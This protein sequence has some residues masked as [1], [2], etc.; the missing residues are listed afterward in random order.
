M[1][2]FVINDVS[3][4]GTVR[5]G[6]SNPVRIMGVLNVSPES[7]YKKSVKRGDVIARAVQMMENEGADFVDVG[8]M[9]TAPY[10]STLVPER[11]EIRRVLDAISRIQ[12]VSNLPISVDTCRSNV[13]MAA[14]NS[15]AEIL[16]DVSG[17]KYDRQMIRVIEK[18]SPSVV[19][20]AYSPRPITGDLM[21][22]TKRLLRQSILLAISAKIKRQNI[23]LDPAIG[24]F[25]NRGRGPF[26]T[27]I[28]SDWLER[29]LNVLQD[30][31]SLKM[32]HPVLVSVSN[33]SF[34]G[35]IIHSKNPSDRI[36]GSLTAEA[37]AVINGADI[38]RTH[39]VRETKS[40][41]SLALKISKKTQERL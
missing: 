27:R 6:G 25:R 24:F 23:V 4:L 35:K 32:N 18:H 11:Q 37:L 34:I 20:C 29:D 40:A 36:F 7:F 9:S 2:Y 38:V 28:K 31:S 13:A 8:G 15:G 3:K 14:L 22:Q 19:L 12:R 1:A 5:V 17:L 21:L 26:Y 41:V 39:N 30:L 10:L 33:K 16:N